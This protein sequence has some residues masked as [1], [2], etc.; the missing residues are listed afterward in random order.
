[1]HKGSGAVV[2]E[3][4]FGVSNATRG[5]KKLDLR[6]QELKD[7]E[8]ARMLQEEEIKVRRSIMF[9]LFVQKKCRDAIFVQVLY[10]KSLRLCN[11]IHRSYVTHVLSYMM[12]E[13]CV[14]SWGKT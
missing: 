4:A 10:N 14:P 9:C 5:L 6:E 2:S 7:M 3:T 8:V 1:M 11:T 13:Q 12:L